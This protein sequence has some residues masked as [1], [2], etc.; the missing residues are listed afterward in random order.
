MYDDDSSTGLRN[1]G[2]L[3]VTSWTLQ[4]RTLVGYSYIIVSWLS[5]TIKPRSMQLLMN[6]FTL[7]H[8][9]TTRAC[10]Q[11]CMV[12]KA[13]IS[14]LNLLCMHIPRS[15]CHTGGFILVK[16]PVWRVGVKCPRRKATSSGEGNVPMKN[17]VECMKT[18]R[19]NPL[20]SCTLRIWAHVETSKY[21]SWQIKYTYIW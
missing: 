20:R 14:H 13:P 16:L 10:L 9:S 19:W 8:H 18:W 3:C 17:K 6:D 2:V 1:G 21:R 12:H 11:A 5:C 4:L 15:V 7:Q